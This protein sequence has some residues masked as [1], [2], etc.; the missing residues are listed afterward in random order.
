MNMS[1]QEKQ[2]GQHDH[3]PHNQGIA[4]KLNWL[5]AGVLGANDGIVSV[6][7]VVVGV[8]GATSETSPVLIAGAAALIGGAVSMALGEYVSVSSSADSQKALIEKER[9]ELADMPDE[10]LVELTGLYEA[11]GLSPQTAAVV[12]RELTEHD[13]LAAHLDIELQLDEDE[14][15]SPWHAA[16]ASAVAFTVGAA[17]PF[18]TAV[19]L[20]GPLKIPVTFIAVMLALG[21]TGALGAKLGG[22]PMLRPTV[23][24]LIGGAAALALTF[25]IG[26]WLGSSGIV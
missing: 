21:A 6:A 7:A 16:F 1:E 8:S 24:V 18:A 5:R 17:L 14:V 13:A 9:R 22:A 15:L 11:K 25:A 26:S 12:A 4:E 23:R 2:Q 19:F 20:P 10:E 3:E